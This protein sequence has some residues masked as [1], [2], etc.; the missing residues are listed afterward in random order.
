MTAKKINKRA[1]VASRQFPFLFLFIIASPFCFSF[2]F[3]N[4]NIYS[5]LFLAIILKRLYF[6]FYFNFCSFFFEICAYFLTF[7]ERRSIRIPIS[8]NLG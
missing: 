7:T 8:E 3:S 4:K 6:L 1:S 5:M 2:Y